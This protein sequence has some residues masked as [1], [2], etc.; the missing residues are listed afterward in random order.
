MSPK[1]RRSPRNAFLRPSERC[2]GC[3]LNNSRPNSSVVVGWYS[4]P[5]DGRSYN[6]P[7][8]VATSSVEVGVRD[9]KNNLSRYLDRVRHGD[10]VIVTDRGRPVARLSALDQPT[11]RLATLIAS[12]AVRAPDSAVRSR[13]VRRIATDRSVSDLVAEQRR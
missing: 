10:E 6:G 9:L 1:Y 7:M 2:G 11:D 8:N 12:G 13:P 4:S 5:D 3:P